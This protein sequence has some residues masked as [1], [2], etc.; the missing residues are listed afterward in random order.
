[1]LSSVKKKLTCSVGKC[2]QRAQG[3]QSNTSHDQGQQAMPQFMESW[4][5]CEG[6]GYMLEM[7]E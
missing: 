4:K 7:Y 1:M 5:S 6:S 3:E 2:M